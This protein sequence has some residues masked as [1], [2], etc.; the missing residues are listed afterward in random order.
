MAT[1]NLTYSANRCTVLRGRWLDPY[2]DKIFYDAHEMDIDHLVP[3]KWAW[4]H[5]AFLWDIGKRRKFANDEVNLFAV[6]ASINREKGSDGPDKWLPPDKAFRC[7]YILRFMRVVKTYQ[8]EITSQE[9]EIF[10][11]ISRQY[12]NK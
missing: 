6:Q 4:D 9:T 8:L 1:G 10:S 2:T 7:Q 5:G 11:I 3:L 12:C